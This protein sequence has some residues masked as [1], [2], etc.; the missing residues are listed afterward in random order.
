MQGLW[1][2]D[3]YVPAAGHRRCVGRLVL[4]G[5]KPG[6]QVPLT[7]TFWPNGA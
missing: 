7:N 4:V 2:V 6:W 5:W 1:I 3:E